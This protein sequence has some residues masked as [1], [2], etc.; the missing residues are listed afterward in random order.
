MKTS[1]NKICW[2]SFRVVLR[3]KRNIYIYCKIRTISVIKLNTIVQLIAQ[4]LKTLGSTA[5]QDRLI[6]N[7]KQETI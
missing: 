3:G 5:F 4:P 6:L 2:K 1:H 7:F